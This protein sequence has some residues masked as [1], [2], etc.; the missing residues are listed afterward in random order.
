[1]HR[2]RV[3]QAMAQELSEGGEIAAQ[4]C[5]EEWLQ[6]QLNPPKERFCLGF[7][8]WI[9]FVW[10]GEPYKEFPGRRKFW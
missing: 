2:Y 9:F 4:Q 8:G 10:R 6:R 3:G 1:M 5:L 7:L